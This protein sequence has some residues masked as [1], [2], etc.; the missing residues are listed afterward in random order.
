MTS[1]VERPERFVR[2]RP[3]ACK[4]LGDAKVNELGDAG[5]FV[6]TQGNQNIR[7]LDIA[8]NNSLLMRML[9]SLTCFLE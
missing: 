8:M 1:K 5:P 6:I 7:R 4:S 9:D 2:Q 3:L